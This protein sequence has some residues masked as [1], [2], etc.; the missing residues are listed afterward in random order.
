MLFISLKSN[1]SL[2]LY[3]E[4]PVDDLSELNLDAGDSTVWRFIRC[5]LRNLYKLNIYDI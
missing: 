1:R 2:R 3:A 4:P 5:G